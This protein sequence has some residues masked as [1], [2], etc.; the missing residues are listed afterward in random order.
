MGY[1][2]TMNSPKIP[3]FTPSNDHKSLG[4][5]TMVCTVPL[6]SI[7]DLVKAYPAGVIDAVWEPEKG[8]DARHEVRFVHNE[9]GNEFFAYARYGVVR[10]GSRSNHE[11]AHELAEFLYKHFV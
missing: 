3:G 9:T 10:I 8:Y 6:V 4:G 5:S 7:D 2:R 1:S 11:L